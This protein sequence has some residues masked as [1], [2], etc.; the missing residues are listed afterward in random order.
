MKSGCVLFSKRLIL[1]FKLFLKS[2]VNKIQIKLQ[3]T[4][5][6][7]AIKAFQNKRTDMGCCVDE[8]MI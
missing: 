2:K 5:L 4:F 1:N 8:F 6:M 7:Y 3:K